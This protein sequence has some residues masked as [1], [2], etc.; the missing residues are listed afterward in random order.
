MNDDFNTPLALAS[1]FELASQ[2]NRT[3]SPQPAALLKSLARTL[4]VLQQVP[5][6]YLQGGSDLDV[7]RIEALIEQRAAA[8]RAR[9]FAGADRIREQLAKQGV[10]LQDGAAGTTWVRA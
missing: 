7:S 3:R 10:V 8:K 2:V 1:L 9:D 4:G 5:L 6:E